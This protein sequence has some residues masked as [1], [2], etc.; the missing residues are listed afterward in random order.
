MENGIFII[1][2]EPIASALRQ[3]AAHVFPEQMGQVA[4]YDVKAKAALDTS[5]EEAAGA[6]AKLGNGPVLILVDV[7]G[8]TPSNIGQRL[9]QGRSG[10]MVTGA[11]LPMLLRAISYRHESLA[12]LAIRAQTG[13][14]QGVVV[15]D[16]A[17]VN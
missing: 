12:N 4:A 17:G 16:D 11:N 3:G 8:A 9:L 2:H 14:I 1:G 5:L 6:L 7:L 13:G 10:K 15:I